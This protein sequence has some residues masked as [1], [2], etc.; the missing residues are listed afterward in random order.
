[1]IE[2]DDLAPVPVREPKDPA[3]GP[4]HVLHD[5]GTGQSEIGTVPLEPPV[6]RS[7]LMNSL[8][9]SPKKRTFVHSGGYTPSPLAAPRMTAAGAAAV[10]VP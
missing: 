6:G 9:M 8:N 5:R 7:V 1:M 10:L 3:L 4:A 2:P